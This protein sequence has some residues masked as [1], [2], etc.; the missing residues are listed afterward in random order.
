MPKKIMFKYPVHLSPLFLN[1]LFLSLCLSTL[2]SSPLYAE[3]EDDTIYEE[4]I[5]EE[6]VDAPEAMEAA[7]NPNDITALRAQMASLTHKMQ[8]LEGELKRA[9]QG[10]SG[11][12]PPG[13]VMPIAVSPIL[14]PK[15]NAVI[16]PDVLELMQEIGATTETQA[17]EAL[18]AHSKDEAV[19]MAHARKHTGTLP[20]GS[21]PSDLDHLHKLY[22]ETMAETEATKLTQKANAFKTACGQYIQTHQTDSSSRSALYYLGRVLLKQSQLKDAQNAFARVYRGDEEGPHAADA[23]LGMCRVLLKQ[24]NTSAV[25]KFL[26]KIKKD[27]KPDYL[28]DDTKA[29]FK[30]VAKETGVTVSLEPSSQKQVVPVKKEIGTV[31]KEIEPSKTAPSQKK[32]ATVKT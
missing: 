6:A 17:Q 1:S 14:P 23:L 9:H 4:V 16:D 3:G 28:S 10:S 13:G 12:P 20:K 18:E 2:V 21:T 19:A 11:T 24:G 15:D 29:S 30:S 25:V 5:E 31:K 32:I 7:G 27:F 26:E 8:R 22:N